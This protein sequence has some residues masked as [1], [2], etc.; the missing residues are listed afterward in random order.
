[1]TAPPLP[2]RD[3]RP[4]TPPSASE[5]EALRREYEDLRARLAEVGRRLDRL[6]ADCRR[7]EDDKEAAGGGVPP[8]PVGLARPE[9]P[10]PAGADE[11]PSLRDL[12]DAMMRDVDRA[13]PAGSAGRRSQS[14]S[15]R[16]RLWRR[17][18][19]LRRA[20][21]AAWVLAALSLLVLAL[22]AVRLAL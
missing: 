1:M 18:A 15:P 17:L 14:G 16:P 13:R 4:A 9:G 5:A 8:S 2:R 21:S 19:A 7:L 11:G 10:R 6:A 12:I 20:A 22:L 3:S